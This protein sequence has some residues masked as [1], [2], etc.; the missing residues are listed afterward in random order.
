MGKV[1]AQR[2]AV[3]LCVRYVGFRVLWGWLEGA[4]LV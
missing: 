1:I 3:R 2:V 4:V